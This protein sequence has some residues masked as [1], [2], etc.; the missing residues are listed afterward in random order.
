MTSIVSYR[1]FKF[2]RPVQVTVGLKITNI[3]GLGAGTL[4][5]GS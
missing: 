5:F 4:L 3:E 1:P 2:I